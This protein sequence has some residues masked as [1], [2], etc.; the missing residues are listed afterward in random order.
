MWL[1]PSYRRMYISI[2]ANRNYLLNHFYTTMT[3]EQSEKITDLYCRIRDAR[4]RIDQY[5]KVLDHLSTFTGEYEPYAF[6]LI[7]QLP[8]G[9]SNTAGGLLPML[10][11]QFQITLSPD[12]V[13]KPI[14]NALSKQELDLLQLEQQLETF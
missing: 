14:A 4:W 2:C 10:P 9:A 1:V 3:F 7:A 11:Q 13:L 12:D 8:M 5:K 6:S